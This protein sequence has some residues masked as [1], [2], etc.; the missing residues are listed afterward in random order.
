M[1]P[2]KRRSGVLDADASIEEIEAAA[3]DAQTRAVAARAHAERLRRQAS[4]QEKKSVFARL[5]EWSRPSWLALPTPTLLA[6]CEAA[7][8]ICA[9]LA[10]TG[11]MLWQHH[12]V[13]QDQ[14]RAAEFSAAAR[15]SVVTMMSIDPATAE[16]NMKDVIAN[17]TGKFKS[18][19]EA[20]EA[21][22]L[23]KGS[24]QSKVV[25]K[26]TIQNVAVESM[27][28]D[29]AVVLVAATTEGTGPNNAKLPAASWR[30][31]LTLVRQNGQLKTSE[32]EFV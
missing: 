18:A 28:P 12:E 6:L 24:Q 13:Q 21:D 30:M 23:I 14:R 25:T 27:T 19:L 15:Q 22:E 29:S 5:R 2:R 10:A 26:A 32:F 7:A 9:A 4:E 17:S 16:Q 1:S 3:F 11:Y 20:G 31:S 8:V